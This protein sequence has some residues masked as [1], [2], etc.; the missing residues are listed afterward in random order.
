MSTDQTTSAKLLAAFDGRDAVDYTTLV[1]QLDASPRTIRRHL[2][3]LVAAG[4]LHRIGHGVYDRK[5]YEPTLNPEAQELWA[6]LQ[7]SDA[8]A[9]ITG[10]DLLAGFAHQF[11][12]DYLHLVY[13]H[14]PH[15]S[16]LA[17]ELSGS[18]WSV[19]PAGP[20][21]RFA[22]E[23]ERSVVLR[24][25]THEEG[26]YPVENHL[27]RPEKAWVD[28][29]REARRSKL[30]FDFGELGRILA[31]MERAGA[32]QGTLSGIRTASRVPRVA[33]RHQ[34]RAPAGQRRAAPASGGLRGVSTPAEHAELFKSPWVADPGLLEQSMRE[35]RVSDRYTAELAAWCAEIHEHLRELAGALGI[36]LLLMGGN[37]ASLRFDAVA[38]RGSRDNDY[39]TAATPENIGRLKTLQTSDKT[40][41]G[42]RDHLPRATPH[43]R[44]PYGGGRRAAAHT[45]VLDG[46]RGLQDHPDIYAHYQPAENEAEIVDRAFAPPADS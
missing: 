17:S 33:A 42:T 34:R 9:H 19:L 14:P 36:E 23:S 6:Q 13:C 18:G 22:T 2:Q 35:A 44:N 3:R 27:A 10:F 41:G 16:G 30:A 21:R 29:L 28:L 1:G 25:Q 15:L 32:R 38:Q 46:P 39:L 26:R 37:G 20:M 45:P 4:A 12:Y 31:A 40:R 11:V 7:A 5:L 43:I 24:G 8:D